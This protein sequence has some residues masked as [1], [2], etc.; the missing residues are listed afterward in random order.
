MRGDKELACLI[1]IQ[2]SIFAINPSNSKF[3]RDVTDEEFEKE[4][5]MYISAS[6]HSHYF[7]MSQE[8]CAVFENSLRLASP[9]PSP[10]S[11]PDFVFDGGFIEHFEITSSKS[12]R[13][14]YDHKRK[15]VAFEQMAE[16]EENAFKTAMNETPSFGTVQSK[17]WSF[18]Y[19]QHLYDYLKKSF[20]ETW[21]H[22]IESLSKYTGNSEIGIFIIEYPETVLGHSI[23]F[24]VLPERLYG[25]MLFQDEHKWY[26]LSRDKDL[27]SFM[28]E[29]REKIKYVVFKN[30]DYFEVLAT[31]TIPELVKLLPWKYQFYPCMVTE[32]RSIYGKSIPYKEKRGED[33]EKTE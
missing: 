24:D 23:D 4:H 21:K 7:G 27:L 10:S 3:F 16:Q 17:S 25:D 28:Y 30:I 15:H 11:F 2:N 19:P 33:N 20:T 8:D 22:H 6:A 13:S 14:G 18:T 32:V 26:R 29:Y 9:N 1:E 5:I 12:N 31:E